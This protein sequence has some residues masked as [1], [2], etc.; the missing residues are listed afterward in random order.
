HR[1]GQQSFGFGSTIN[2]G[3]RNYL[4]P[5]PFTHRNKDIRIRQQED[6]KGAERPS[7]EMCYGY[8]KI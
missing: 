8:R 7:R 6:R 5:P 3:R 2:K 4:T 1:D